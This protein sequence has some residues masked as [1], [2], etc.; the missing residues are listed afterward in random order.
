MNTALTAIVFL[1][2][3]SNAVAS[4]AIPL[5]SLANSRSKAIWLSSLAPQVATLT[6]LAVVLAT[7]A[8]PASGFLSSEKASWILAASATLGCLL[9]SLAIGVSAYDW[10]THPGV[11]SLVPLALLGLV[12][13]SLSGDLLVALA[14]WLLV[15]I[16][17][18][19]LVAL[20]GDR[21]SVRAA[22]IYGVVGMISTLLLILGVAL[23]SAALEAG[24]ELLSLSASTMILASLGLK[25]GLFPFHWWIPAVYGGANGR[26]VAVLDGSYKPAFAAALLYLLSE[27]AGPVA[28]QV[29]LALLL[30][31]LAS[32]TYGNVAAMVTGRLQEL[33][34][35]SS[36]AHA[37]FIGIAISI[38]LAPETTRSYELAIAGLLLVALTVASAKPPLFALSSLVRDV[39]DLEKISWDRASSTSIAVLSLSLLGVPPLLGFWGKLVIAIAVAEVSP[40]VAAIVLVNVTASSVYYL[41]VVVSALRRSGERLELDRAVRATLIASTAINSLGLIVAATIYSL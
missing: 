37:G 24:R 4:L 36:I 3:Y 21:S 19:A 11:Y 15:A 13:L 9:S 28:Q 17:S 8:N 6:A 22:V 34:A 41:R 30:L 16:S 33:L 10:L 25:L 40:L 31:G 5:L 18:Y 32:M 2:L 27:V 26:L 39:G 38:A 29:S 23:G 14:A 12:H 20:A 35:Y 7:G 1:A